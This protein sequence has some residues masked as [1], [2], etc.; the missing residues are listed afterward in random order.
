MLQAMDAAG[1]PSSVHAE[2]RAARAILEKARAQVAA[3]AGCGPDEVIFTSGA[4]EAARILAHPP[5]GADIFVDE[6]AHDCLWTHRRLDAVETEPRS[7]RYT[8][9]WGLANSETG[10]IRRPSRDADGWAW[11]ARARAGAL[12]L[13]IVQVAGRLPLSFRDEGADLAIVS[14]HKLGGPKGVGALIARA[15]AEI[16]PLQEG[17]GQ[18]SRRRA[19]TE[20]LPGI[21]GFGAAAEAAARD[22]EAGVWTAVERLRNILEERLSVASRDLIF[23]ER[24]A[25]RLPNTS[26]FA[27][28]GWKGETQVMQMD[29]AGFA[30]SAGSACS[31]G[32][33]GPSR[34][35]KAMGLDDVAAQSAIRVSLGPTTAEAE[36]H[37][38]AD[39]WIDRHRRFAAKR[40][41][42]D[43]VAA[44]A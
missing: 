8:L 28:P 38:F 31:S 2:G 34:V 16:A 18:E 26:C 30:V 17:G 19:G 32:K 12:L 24:E 7:P 35:L 40:P 21:A 15:G 13:D 20:N 3:L 42:E 37:A 41:A 23:V 9:A 11:G 1:N 14:A 5:R 29:L 6:T 36:V 44:D 10:V 33:V 27:V 4:T 43:R 25:R 22:L 39:A